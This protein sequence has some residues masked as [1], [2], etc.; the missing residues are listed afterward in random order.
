M[1]GRR[2]PAGALPALL[3]ALLLT[4]VALPAGTASFS[5]LKPLEYQ[6][7]GVTLETPPREIRR[8]LKRKGYLLTRTERTG[9]D[10]YLVEAFTAGKRHRLFTHV[11]LASCPETGET[12]GIYASGEDGA[13]I[14]ARARERYGIKGT[15]LAVPPADG[16]PGGF[17]RPERAYR[18]VYPNVTVSY[19][20]IKNFESYTLA[21]ESPAAMRRCRST[22]ASDA[23]AEEALRRH[24][25]KESRQKAVA[26]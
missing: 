13:T 17:M 9:A 20:K 15:D 25:Q 2:L 21:F 11:Y 22:R 12:V 19:Y 16:G 3:L 8:T 10:A 6:V 4:F 24:I 1:K 5:K 14:L 23:L 7:F 26:D 18:K